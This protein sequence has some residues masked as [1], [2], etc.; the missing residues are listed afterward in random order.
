MTQAELITLLEGWGKRTDLSAFMPTFIALAEV[1]MNRTIRVREMEADLG[2][3]TID[4]AGQIAL[5]TDFAAFKTLWPAGSPSS[6][7]T[8]STL[9]AIKREPRDGR[10]PTLMHVGAD[11]V[12][13]NG[14]G[15]VEG[16]YYAR[17]PALSAG[18]NWLSTRHMDAYLFGALSELNSF[19]FNKEDAALYGA[20]FEAAIQEINASGQRDRHAG[21]LTARKQ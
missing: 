12:Q 15:D 13:F 11:S 19:V 16:V 21:Q 9:E 3:Q 5:P 7:V 18:A 4:S 20:R 14:V 2:L 6:P 8:D 17:I 1:K 10:S